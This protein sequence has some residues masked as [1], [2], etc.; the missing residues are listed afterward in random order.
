METTKS[1]KPRLRSSINFT[2]GKKDI[3]IPRGKSMTVPDDSFTVAEIIEKTLS[4]MPPAINQNYFYVEG[5]DPD[6]D[7]PDHEDIQRMSLDEKHTLSE[8]SKS[9]Q[10][11]AKAVVE[12]EKKKKADAAAAAAQ[13]AKEAALEEKLR[14]KIKG[15]KGPQKPD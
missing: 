12:S 2:L 11:Q 9:I 14:E 15:E 13:A 5:E 4:G 10:A 8:E 1:K 6:F 7:D 3:E